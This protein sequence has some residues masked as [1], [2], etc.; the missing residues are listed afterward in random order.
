MP[1]QDLTDIRTFLTEKVIK[2]YSGIFDK[3]TTD[4][5]V[6]IRHEKVSKPVIYIG[7]GTCGIIS[8]AHATLERVQQYVSE[9]NLK[10]DIIEVGC[11]GFCSAEP[12][13]DVQL[14]GKTRL[15]F[16]NVTEDRAE[17]VLN[18]VFHHTIQNDLTLGQY[19]QSG[20]EEWPNVPM[21]E[22][23]P[24]FNLQT[25]HILKN[26]GIISPVSIEE[27]IARGGYKSLYKTVLNYPAD[28]ICEI[29]EQ[30][31]L[32][33]RAGGGFPTGRKW[34]IALDTAGDQKYMICN[35]DES[36]P[37]AFMDRAV[38]ESDPHRIIEG[39]SIAAYAIGA[40]QA[41]IYVR[42]D[43]ENPLN[44]LETA[45][46]QAKEYGLLGEDIFG[47]GFNLSISVRQG[48]G[49]FVCGEETALIS[50]LEGQRGLPRSKPPYPAE[51]GIWGHPTVINNV[52]TLA[53]IPGILENG[54]AWFKA[55][56]TKSS[57]G[58]KLFSLAGKAINTGFI[59]VPMGITFSS[60]INNIAGGVKDGKA[61]KA[62]QLG[63]P[64]GVC[65]PPADLDTPLDFE[66]LSGIGAKLGSGGLIILDEKTCMVN[67][68]KYFIDF[69]QN[70]S[71]GKCI[72][73]RE[74]TKK[75]LDILEG[76]TR[77]PKE[78]TTH[79]TLERFKGVV[80]LESL[81]NVI[82]DTSLCGLGQNA[83]NPVLSS[84]KW[85]REEF[86]EH[87]F[88][89]RCAAGVC[90]DLRTFY[91]DVEHCNGCNICQKKCPENAIVGSPKMPHFII[92]S[93]CTGCGVC[94]DVCKFS[95]IYFK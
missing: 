15:C 82:C 19:K 87:I 29:I 35:A 67:L 89:R 17:D 11:N 30:S 22:Q 78:E 54:P 55:M 36:D 70:E 24:W 77:R 42:S 32:K 79:E 4:R 51:K 60:I 47:S 49:A 28:K 62:V 12:L 37:G 9:N 20:L 13:L 31:E 75:M 27:Y 33:G 76:I 90:H 72:P 59:E 46:R 18:S 44:I 14:P 2:N 6:A 21:L 8:G 91:I 93:K 38:I 81:A 71:C 45:I 94:F 95:A 63:G 68:A 43:Y 26:A 1:A 50:S 61:L 34:K 53:N 16:R 88:D 84:L 7:T 86:E 85:F 52:E 66:A 48:A 80:H 83:P 5:L 10:A 58:T 73:C 41:I 74:G 3:P 39:L 40:S 65:I 25:R 23:I 57:K 56:G 69:L 64:S 92:E